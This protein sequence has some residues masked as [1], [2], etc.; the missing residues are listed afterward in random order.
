MPDRLPPLNALRAFEAAARHM[1][2]AEA[3]VE[4]NVTPAALSQQI[5]S[6]EAH[7]GT[8]VFRRLNRRVELTEVGQMLAPGISD[9]FDALRGAW[10]AAIRRVDQKH[11]TVTSGPVFLASW[12]APRMNEFVSA[13]PEVELRFTASLRTLNFQRDG[14]DLAVRFGV[15]DDEGY[16]SETIFEDWATPMC[17]PETANSIRTPADVLNLPLIW[18]DSGGA[19]AAFEGWAEWCAAVGLP[20][21][22]RHGPVFSG[23]DGASRYASTG[24]GV[25]MGR[26]SLADLHLREGRLVMPL[27][28]TIK[29]GLRYRIVCPQGFETT[30]RVVMF[31]D[32]IRTEI[33]TLSDWEADREFL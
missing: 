30:P 20:E 28:Q 23:G 13:H 26:I 5:K 12:L 27:K 2:F 4:L 17:S 9:G 1:S 21:P 3:A 14:I 7:L 33:G 15:G 11:L 31:R 8:E 10:S 16:F 25:M 19:L 29:R 24:G 32:W 18:Q 22:E 6:L